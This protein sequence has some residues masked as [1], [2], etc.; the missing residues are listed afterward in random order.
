M[1]VGI[2][3][4]HSAYNFGSV[5]QAYAT[6][7]IVKSIGCKATIINYRM[8]SQKD[9]YSYQYQFAHTKSFFK[10]IMLFKKKE[11]LQHRAVRYEDFFTNYLSLTDEFSSP[12]DAT[13]YA[14]TFDIYISGSDQIW[15]K[16]SNELQNEAWKF[17]GPYLLDF[18]NKKK[19]SYASSIVN[20]KD[21]ELF[22]IAD[23]IKKFSKLS[24]REQEAAKRL[25]KVIQ[26]KVETVLDP[27]L[28]LTG[29]EW[30]I[31]LGG[32]KLQEPY[33]LLYT[34]ATNKKLPKFV[35]QARK[36]ATQYGLKLIVLSPLA[37]AMPNFFGVEF[38]NDAGP[39]EFLRLVH[40][41]KYI[42]TDSYHGTLFSLNFNKQF[43]SKS[44]LGNLDRRIEQILDR[45]DL[46][47]RLISGI[48]EADFS[49]LLDYSKVKNKLEKYRNESITYLKKALEII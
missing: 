39:K 36:K 37:M 17:M 29:D 33:L 38:V 46:K 34:M 4:Y 42:I 10:K 20:M 49:H 16:H 35:F 47:Y 45:L 41:A 30:E 44:L 14:E 6:Q 18:T 15:N 26:T 11:S 19:I 48:D 27:T 12:E 32:T 13:I 28:L 3:T 9:F 25:E 2:I 40:D 21:K 43:F 5:L 24:C 22:Y 8:K 23:K 7:Q 1:K 31:L